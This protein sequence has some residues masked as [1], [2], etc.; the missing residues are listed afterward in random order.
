MVQAYHFYAPTPAQDSD[1]RNPTKNAMPLACL[2]VVLI[3]ALGAATFDERRE[4]EQEQEQR[5][6]EFALNLLHA[7]DLTALYA[8]INLASCG[9][10]LRADVPVSWA[11][12]RYN[13]DCGKC[14]AMT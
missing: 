2:F 4:Q 8:E 10:Q 13:R 1:V 9:G 14:G 3:G 5:D 6:R 12:L 11:D 7:A